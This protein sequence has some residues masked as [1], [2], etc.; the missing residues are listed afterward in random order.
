[1]V[2]SMT[3]F[4]KVKDLTKALPNSIDLL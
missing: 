4:I 3:K 1:M 2:S